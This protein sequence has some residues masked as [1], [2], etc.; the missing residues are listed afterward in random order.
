MSSFFFLPNWPWFVWNK[1]NLTDAKNGCGSG[2]KYLHSVTQKSKCLARMVSC[3]LRNNN[4]RRSWSSTFIKY[5][6]RRSPGC[7]PDGVD[8]PWGALALTSHSFWGP[9][10]HYIVSPKT[11]LILQHISK[12][13]DVLVKSL[14]RLWERG[15]VPC[16]SP[17]RNF[18]H[19]PIRRL[20]PSHQRAH[21]CPLLLFSSFLPPNFE[22]PL[23]YLK[24][25]RL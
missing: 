20:S 6:G 4:P 25:A 22:S 9:T 12:K 10:P 18:I 3:L 5:M 8:L 14:W 2:Q 19:D 16:S 15:H 7:S 11:H 24:K 17:S 23:W 1:R 21:L 13:T